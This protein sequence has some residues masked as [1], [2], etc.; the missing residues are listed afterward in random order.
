MKNKKDSFDLF[1]ENG[2]K[3]KELTEDKYVYFNDVMKYV[4]QHQKDVIKA[5]IILEAV[6]EDLLNNNKSSSKNIKEYVNKIEKTISIKEKMNFIKKQDSEKFTISGL[7][8]TMCS[9]I[10]ILFIK[11]FLTGNYLINFS[12]DILVAIVAFYITLHNLMSQFKM[13]R[14]HHLSI[15]AFSMELIG[16]AVAIFITVITLTSPFDISFVIL[17]IAYLTSKKIFEKELSI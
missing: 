17:V 10:V 8:L 5:N 1:Y 3:A 14:R 16:I 12:V 6:L 4:F 11:E 2:L 7:W 15:R 9:Y 13:I